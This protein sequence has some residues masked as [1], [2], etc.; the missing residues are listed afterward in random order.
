MFFVTVYLIRVFVVY[1]EKSVFQES[2]SEIL[3]MP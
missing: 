3:V 1:Q 2:L